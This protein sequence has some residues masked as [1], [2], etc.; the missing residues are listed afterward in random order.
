MAPLRLMT[1][2]KVMDGLFAT[3]SG[4]FLGLG[5][6]LSWSSPA[7]AHLGPSVT[8]LCP[9]G[10]LNEIAANIVAEY[11]GEQMARNVKVVKHIDTARCLNGIRDHEAPIALVPG[12]QWPGDDEIVVHVG[13]PLRIAGTDF[14]LVMGRKA[15]RRLRYSLVPRYMARLAEVL[16]GTDI[17]PG[18][19]KVRKG[20]GARKVALDLLRKVDL[21]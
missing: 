7:S 8:L 18:L 19:E 17:S 21:L 10:A 14:V 20:E 13:G 4:L 15:A 12:D 5:L 11:M 2:Q 3:L 16:T 6:L 1:S 9:E